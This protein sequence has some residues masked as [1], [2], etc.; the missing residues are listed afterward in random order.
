MIKIAIL[1]VVLSLALSSAQAQVAQECLVKPSADVRLAVK[2]PGVVASVTVS[3]GDTVTEGQVLLTQVDDIEAANLRIAQARAADTS[4]VDGAR[5]RRQVAEAQ[6][7]RLKKLANSSLVTRERLDEAEQDALI[8]RQEE[9]AAAAALAIAGL[10]AERALAAR[11]RLVLRAPLSGVITDRNVDPGE[12]ASE[13]APVLTIA[14]L[15]PLR[16]EAWI[17]AAEWG[18]IKQG[19]MAEI[20]SE[21]DPETR[22]PAQIVAVDPVLETVSSTF[23]VTFDVPNPDGTMP[24]GV[25]CLLYLQ[26]E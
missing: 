12:F 7:D 18:R 20:A 14:T 26:D 5:A 2:T 17:D 1:P 13:Q 19:D 21:L 23:R 25:A 11:D 6:L 4:G 10:E 9:N 22:R 3:R 8:L 16:V 15:D 24:A